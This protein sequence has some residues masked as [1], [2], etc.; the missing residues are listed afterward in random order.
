MRRSGRH[1]LLRWAMERHLQTRPYRDR[2]S[3]H[4]TRPVLVAT[5]RFVE[6][7]ISEN[8]CIFGRIFF[9]FVVETSKEGFERSEEGRGQALYTMDP[10]KI[11][12]SGM[13]FFQ[14][15]WPHSNNYT[16][17]YDREEKFNLRPPDISINTAR[18]TGGAGSTHVK[19][20]RC[21]KKCAGYP[22]SSDSITRLLARSATRLCI[23]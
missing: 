19:L 22:R 13:I 3:N 23:S 18:R 4:P 6:V 17:Q 7:G 5:A 14:K 20:R 2:A 1:L 11:Y 12:L 16:K 15:R 8:I 10:H 9:F 21:A